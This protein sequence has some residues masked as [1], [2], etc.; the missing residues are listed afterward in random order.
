M[1]DTPFFQ[2]GLWP[3]RH[4]ICLATSEATAAAESSA[5]LSVCLSCTL[6]NIPSFPDPSCLV[7]SRKDYGGLGHGPAC[8]PSLRLVLSTSARL[9]ERA[10]YE[11]TIT[12]PSCLATSRKDCGGLGDVSAFQCLCLPGTSTV[13]DDRHT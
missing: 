10:A 13:V 1:P 2:S 3:C 9:P 8:L 11:L 5:Y 4:P 6:S 12:H 7:T